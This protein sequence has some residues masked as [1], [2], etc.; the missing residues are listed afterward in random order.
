MHILI[1]GG[2]GFIGQRLAPALAERGDRVTVLSRDPARVKQRLGPGVA[3]IG[4]LQEL[5]GAT[6]DAVVN[7]AGE[8]L[9]AGRW[10]TE[11]KRAF[12]TSRIGTTRALVEHFS[13]SS[14]RPQ[15]LVSGSAIGWYGSRAD[16][17]LTEASTAGKD[18]AA[19]LCQ[20]WES[21]AQRAEALGIRVCRVR[22]G[23][24]LG[25]GGA[26]ASML[27]PFRL[28]LGG[29]IGDGRQW[30]SWIAREDLV[31]LLIWMIDT[32]A[33]EGV[34]NGTAPEPVSNREFAKALGAALRRPA[35]LPTPPL[36]L[37]LLFG[38]MSGLLLGSQRVIPERALRQGFTFR[39]ADLA[40]ALRAALAG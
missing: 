6:P 22:I 1:T 32:P 27:P 17:D 37:K 14:Q 19:R 26:L 31:R 36:L 3:G 11:R 21:E 13:S 33:A 9:G 34:Y 16:E 20:D 30:M 23:V 7:L 38:E 24:V 25:P 10:T 35:L 40:G 12:Q 2:T 39:Q 5:S 18:F 8:N 29:P 4:R 15:V 28:G